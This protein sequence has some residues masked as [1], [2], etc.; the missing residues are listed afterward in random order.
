MAYKILIVD[1]DY[2][3]LDLARTVFSLK[4]DEFRLTTEHDPRRVKREIEL[5]RLDHDLIMLDIAMPHVSGKELLEMI[6]TNPRCR[7]IPVVIVTGSERPEDAEECLEAGADYFLEK[8]FRVETIFAVIR[9][10]LRK[11]NAIVGIAGKIEIG[12]VTIDL[13]AREAAI[14]GR[15]IGLTVTEFDIFLLLAERRDQVVEHKI[16]LDRVWNLRIPRN[17]KIPTRRLQTHTDNIRRKLGSN[18]GLIQTKE[19]IGL[20]FN[21]ELAES[22]GYHIP[23]NKLVENLPNKDLPILQPE[24]KNSINAVSKTAI[25]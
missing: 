23:Q 16:I 15:P 2:Q 17:E 6:K 18:S 12:A 9:T 4:N 21:I 3:I 13:N 25:N 24:L 1:D 11:T 22:L 14:A 5:G 19:G 8:P 20:K 7:R 10:V